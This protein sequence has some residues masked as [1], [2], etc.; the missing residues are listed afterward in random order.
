MEDKLTGINDRDGNHFNCCE[1]TLLI[2]NDSYPLPG[3]ESNIMKASSLTGAGVNYSGSACGAVVGTATALGLVYGT[4]GTESPEE[5]QE[6]RQKSRALMRPIVKA[7]KEKFG[8]INCKGLTG[9]D[10][11]VDED[12]KKWSSVSERPRDDCINWAA[13]QV[14]DILE[15]KQPS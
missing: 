10:F 14:I 3:F 5:F 13:K 7:F 8:S 11:L 9:L 1:S 2:V 6:K 12:R 15:A 4:D